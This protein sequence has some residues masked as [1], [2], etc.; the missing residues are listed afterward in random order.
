MTGIVPP[1]PQVFPSPPPPLFFYS[2]A[3]LPADT[4]FPHV[5][6]C[7]PFSQGQREALWGLAAFREFFST[8]LVPGNKGHPGT[9][10]HQLN[11]VQGAWSPEPHS[12]RT[13]AA[14]PP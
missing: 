13:Q 1:H 7:Y 14:S 8:F 2:L 6:A 3:L 5:P 11:E 9:Q 4:R 10:G 12:A